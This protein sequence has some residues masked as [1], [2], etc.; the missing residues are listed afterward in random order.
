M[1]ILERHLHITFSTPFRVG[2]GLGRGLGVDHTAVRDADD[3]PYI[4]GS[5]LKGRLRSICKRLAL[6]LTADFG[7]DV[8]QTA[9]QPAACQ[10]QGEDK[11][12]IICQLFGSRFWPGALRFGDGRLSADQRLAFQ[13]RQPLFP[14]GL[15]PE[16]SQD[17]TQVRLN[18]RRGVAE[19]KLLFTGET[20]SRECSFSATIA[21]ISD[22]DSRAEILLEYGVKMLTHLG[23]QK[24]RGLGQCCLTLS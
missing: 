24:S 18:R 4:P 7:E 13:L 16:L 20:I 8:C 21:I 3:L 15:D 10:P 19:G 9:A 23:A 17:R 1:P 22:L 2:S 5:M 6:S 12:C 11:P 14:G